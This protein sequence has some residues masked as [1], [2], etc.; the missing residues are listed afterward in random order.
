[1]ATLREQLD[2]AMREFRSQVNVARITK[3]VAPKPITMTAETITLRGEQARKFKESPKQVL[4][5]M[6]SPNKSGH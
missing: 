2:D 5:M 4:T 3:S 1:M 6:F